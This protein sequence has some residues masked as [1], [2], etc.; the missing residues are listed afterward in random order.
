MGQEPAPSSDIS[1][2]PEAALAEPVVVDTPTPAESMQS[3]ADNTSA[4][5]DQVAAKGSDNSELVSENVPSFETD[6]ES[7]AASASTAAAANAAVVAETDSS[8]VSAETA[9]QQDRVEALADQEIPVDPAALLVEKLLDSKR[10]Y[11]CALA[12]V[13]LQDENLD[14]ADLEGADLSGAQLEGVDF[15]GAN[16]K[17]VSFRGANLRNVDLRNADLYKADLSGADLS[18]ARLEGAQLDEANFDGS[19]GYQPPLVPVQ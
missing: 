9:D 1:A 5:P 14:D 4:R 10:C 17:N 16:L 2:T 13:N 15:E 3:A 18:G 7:M 8:A 19:V 6:K 12:G 11:G